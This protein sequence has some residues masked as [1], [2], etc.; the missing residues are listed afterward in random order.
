MLK[1]SWL[2]AFQTAAGRRK[3][4]RAS[5]REWVC[6]RH[7]ACLPGTGAFE[8]NQCHCPIDMNYS[9]KLTSHPAVEVMAKAFG[10]WPIDHADRPL[11][12]RI[13]IAGVEG[14]RDG[15]PV[16]RVHNAHWYQYSSYATREHRRL[17]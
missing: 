13:V 5:H 2:D 8:W 14:Q 11:Q 9:V 15:S 7:L 12:E 10:F 17:G 1:A 3:N 16:D 4:P 6:F